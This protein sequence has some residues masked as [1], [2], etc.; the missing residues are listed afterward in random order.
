MLQHSTFIS[1]YIWKYKAERWLVAV[2]VAVAHGFYAEEILREQHTE[3]RKLPLFNFSAPHR[4]PKSPSAA[5]YAKIRVL[6]CD[7]K[8]RKRY[9]S[10]TEESPVEMVAENGRYT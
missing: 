3:K 7:G 6:K 1:F 10:P 4:F 8:C 5:K 9:T 2:A